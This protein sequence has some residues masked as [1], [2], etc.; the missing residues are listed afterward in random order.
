MLIRKVKNMFIYPVASN[1]FQ[2][3]EHLRKTVF[4]LPS[5]SSRPVQF[6]V[7]GEI[8]RK[9]TGVK[10]K[11]GEFVKS[12]ENKKGFSDERL[13]IIIDEAQQYLKDGVDFLYEFI[14]AQKSSVYK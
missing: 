5:K 4:S 3:K 8:G 11:L 10:Y 1:S 12:Y 6:E 13:A 7:T 9:V 14:K 2:S